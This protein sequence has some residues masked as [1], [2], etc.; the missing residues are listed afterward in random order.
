LSFLIL[1]SG[2]LACVVGLIFTV[3][4]ASLITVVTYL[5]LLGAEKPESKPAEGIWEVDDFA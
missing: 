5:A 3:P 4:L 1:L 2:L